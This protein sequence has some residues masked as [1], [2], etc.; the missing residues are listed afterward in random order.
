LDVE[1]KLREETI[2]SENVYS[3]NLVD[4]VKDTVRLPNGILTVRE[5]VKHRGVVTMLPVI[6]E[7]LIMVRQ[8]R[9]ACGKTLLELPAGTLN[10]G[11]TPDE[12]ARREL[13]EETGYVPGRLKRLLHFYM[14]PGFCS[15]QVYLYLAT[16]LS[17]AVQD[18]EADEVIHVVKVDV[19]TALHLIERNEIE[20]A[21]SIAGI[22]FFTKYLRHP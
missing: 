19:A 10:P 7:G 2:D 3:G 8:F 16:D 11:E 22:L 20:D 9:H 21:K 13:V 12:A 4:V 18:L 6:D 15:E 1:K 5:T 14:S 17:P